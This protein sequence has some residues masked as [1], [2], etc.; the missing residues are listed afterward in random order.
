[1][2]LKVVEV[3]SQ[4]FSS[5]DI[6]PR[7]SS[8]FS[9][10]CSA[11]ILPYASSCTSFLTCGSWCGRAQHLSSPRQLSLCLENLDRVLQSCQEKDLVLNWEKCHF[12]VREGI[13]L[14]H[15]VSQRGIEVDKAKIVIIKRVPPPT[16][17]KEIWSFL[18]H[19]GLSVIHRQFL[20]NH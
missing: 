17:V 9:F 20:P 8:I 7:Y 4:P 19:A 13:I 14:G 3:F 15:L 6:R 16:N 12:M 5:L 10:L 11:L 2:K 18:G 1:M